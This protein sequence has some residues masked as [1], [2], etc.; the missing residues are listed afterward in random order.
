MMEFCVKKIEQL[1]TKEELPQAILSFGMERKNELLKIKNI[2]KVMESV[3]ATILMNQLLLD[4]GY[5]TDD[6]V[7]DK[8]GAP[9]L[10]KQTQL[11]CSIS[12]SKEYVACAISNQPI[13]IDIQI[14]KDINYTSIAKR[15]F[16]PQEIKCLSKVSENSLENF[17]QIWTSK[18]SYLKMLGFGLKRDLHSFYSNLEKKQIFDLDEICV[19]N[20]FL[21][22]YEQY[23]LCIC[24]KPIKE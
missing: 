21:K 15:F 1:I 11:H 6:L 20:L 17:Y 18:E 22:S 8:N 19:G 13:G 2:S 4:S 10:I 23:M 24:T 9:R 14:M 16:H 3:A 5:A 12:H 7:K